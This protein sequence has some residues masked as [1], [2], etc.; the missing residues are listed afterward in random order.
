[1]V[2]YLKPILY[3]STEK[4]F[5][6]NGVG[7]LSDVL[8]CIVEEER[9][10]AYE[11]TMEY[12]IGGVHFSE[13]VSRAIILAKPNSS[14]RPQPFRIY[15]MGKPL[16]GIVTVY[17]QHI[18][19][20]LSGVAVS[21]FS[22][23]GIDKVISA[24]QAGS[25]PKNHGF[26]ITTDKAGSTGIT[27]DVPVSFRALLGGTEGSLLDVYGGEYK[28]DRFS[29][30][31]T[32]KRGAK[33]AFAI[34]YGKNM[35]SF[36]QEENCADIYTD[37][38]PYWINGDEK[39]FLNEKTVRASGTYDFTKVLPLDM[40]NR[41]ETAPS[42]EELKAAAK[43]YMT[44]NKIGVPRVSLKLSYE[45]L[46]ES[47]G[48]AIGLCDTVTV[49]FPALNVNTEAKIVRVEYDVLAERYKSLEIGSTV[50]GLAGTIADNM[51]SASE[52]LGD[53]G[54]Q[55]AIANA[56]SW[57]TRTTGGNVVFKRGAHGG[58]SEI[59]IMDTE[60]V[61][62]ATKVWRINLGGFGFSSKGINGPYET[63]ITQDGH[64]VAKFVDVGTLTA[65]L[66][67]SEDKKSKWNLRTGDM[68]LFNTKLSTIGSGAT[69][70]NA[71]YSKADLDRIDQINVKAVVPTLADYEKLDVNGDGVISITD[72]VQVQQIIDGMRTVNFT[73]QWALR[74]NPSDGNE[75]LKVYRVYHNNSTGED[76]ENV[77][78][79]VGFAN[80][81][82]NSLEAINM[83]AEKEISASSAKFDSLFVDGQPYQP[84]ERVEIGYVVYCTGGSGNKAGCFIPAGVSGTYQ[85][86]SNDWYCSFSFDGSGGATKTGGT[87][88]VAS[89]E[90]I[91]NG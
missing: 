84:F 89:V 79:S 88:T 49:I 63:A 61:E 73:T 75:L 45:D 22:A 87:G 20:D 44:A 27:T 76:T 91:Y 21:P 86:A 1:M 53:H 62:T 3:K 57:L 34:R 33:R 69:Y 68:E 41:F 70:Q 26:T 24:M 80:V 71:D 42:Q 15:Q 32:D 25:I 39:V 14:D 72:A 31:L 8:S 10:G 23:T 59:Y 11:L 66:I 78:F 65:I 46:A 43:N 58:I 2:E 90:T 13:L 38:Y 48:E 67:Q 47:Q 12:P 6:T 37:V 17:A 52:I 9:N 51:T 81:K 83:A 82:M 7:V 28:Y 19:Y 30:L 56:T 50:S 29:I 36:E 74:I 60:N 16:N 40:S 85:C 64:V 35:T 77:V 5:L 18:S 55:Q 54:L 4:T